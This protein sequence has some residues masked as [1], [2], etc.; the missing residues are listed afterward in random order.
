MKTS[1][2]SREV[3]AD[4]IELVARGHMFDGVVAL[5]ACDKTIPAAA[6]ALLR[7]NIPGV[8]LYGGSILPGKHNGRD[9][10]VQDVF[11]AVG[12]HSAGRIDDA[13][14]L[15]IENAACPGAGA[16]GG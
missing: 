6:M 10:T 7:L 9:L 14:L 3:I 12:A 5:V 11:E 13:E 15:A 16:C 4:S 8:V 2:I 1:L